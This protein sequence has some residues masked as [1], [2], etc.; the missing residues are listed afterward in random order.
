MVSRKG[1]A[2]GISAAD[3]PTRADIERTA[4]R[5]ITYR[6]KSLWSECR[7]LMTDTYVNKKKER[8]SSNLPEAELRSLRPC[9]GRHRRLTGW[10][11]ARSPAYIERVLLEGEFRVNNSQSEGN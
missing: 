7:I 9:R 1:A 6:A 2:G 4:A 5:G 8:F 10:R 3:A 11:S